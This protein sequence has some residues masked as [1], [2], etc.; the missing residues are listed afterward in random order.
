MAITD[1]L[2]AAVLVFCLG[3]V[4]TQLFQPAGYE[5]D[6]MDAKMAFHLLLGPVCLAVLILVLDGVADHLYGVGWLQP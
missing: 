1:S 5:A 4:V 3:V 6:G 2:V